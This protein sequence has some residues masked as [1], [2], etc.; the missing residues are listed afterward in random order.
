MVINAP[1]NSDAN[2]Y[3]WSLTFNGKPY[4]LNYFNHTDLIKGGVLNYVM[5]DKPNT[6]RGIKDSSAPYSLSNEK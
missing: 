2:Q 1:N 3:V 5:S 6:Q 4:D